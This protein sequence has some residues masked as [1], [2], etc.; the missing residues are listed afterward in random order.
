MRPTARKTGQLMIP[1]KPMWSAET[2]ICVTMT[3]GMT[4][5]TRRMPRRSLIALEKM[6]VDLAVQGDDEPGQR[7]DEDGD[8]AGQA[9]EDEAD[10]QDGDVDAGGLGQPAADAGQDTRV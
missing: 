7:V 9:D 8:A 6:L 4:A 10:P 5:M 3:T 1:T 2:T